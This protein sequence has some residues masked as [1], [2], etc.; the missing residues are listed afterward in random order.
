MIFI[1]C[2]TSNSELMV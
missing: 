1:N 2:N